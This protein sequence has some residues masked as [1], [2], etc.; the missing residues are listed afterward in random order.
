MALCFSDTTYL[1]SENKDKHFFFFFKWSLICYNKIFIL[2]TE[3]LAAIVKA[4]EG[5]LSVFTVL[6]TRCH[7]WESSQ[8]DQETPII[9][10]G[11]P[12]VL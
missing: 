10:I 8:R 12:L 1:W 9:V 2:I 4:T 7:S 6:V 3:F 11:D 5:N